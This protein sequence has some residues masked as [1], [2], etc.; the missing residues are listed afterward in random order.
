MST[1]FV[2]G[3]HHV[4]RLPSQVKERLDNV[5][6][7][8]FHI[9]VGDANGADKAVQKYLVDTSYTDVTVFC[10]GSTC[11][12][13][14]G[15]WST[16]KIQI[17][18]AAKGFQFYAAKDRVMAR[19]PDFGLMVWDGNSP[20]TALNGLRLLRA[21]K[22]AVLFDVPARRATTLKVRQIGSLFSLRRMMS[23]G[24]GSGSVRRTRNGKRGSNL[25]SLTAG[26]ARGAGRR[27]RFAA[28]RV[29]ASSSRIRK[30]LLRRL[31]IL[32]ARGA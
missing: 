17:P 16:R 20:G 19:E 4:S 2:G 10:S 27:A 9:I 31:V 12:N 11:W 7:Q 1:I 32:R 3:S 15:N 26:R 5:R 22:K 8:D 23:C 29:G 21:G 25:I 13:N 18:K 14:L 28:K 6:A 30:Q 24:A